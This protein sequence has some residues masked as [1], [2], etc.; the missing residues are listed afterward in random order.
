MRDACRRMAQETG[1]S[2]WIRNCPDGTVEAVFE[3][4]RLWVESMCSWCHH[5][6]KHAHVEHVEVTE[7]EPRGEQGFEIVA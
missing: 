6:T 3:G 7:E 1:V 2:G 4:E 5:G